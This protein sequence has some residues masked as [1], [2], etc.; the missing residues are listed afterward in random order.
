[1]LCSKQ[2]LYSALEAIQNLP[3]LVIGDIILDR[4]IWG[5]VDRISSEAPVPV[6]EVKRTEDRL[7]G[8]GNVVRNLR[9]V[10]AKVKLCGLIGEDDE[11]KL[12]LELLKAEGVEH[13][14]VI[15]DRARPTT[16]KTRVIAHAQQVVRIDRESRT[17]AAAPLQEGF[18]AVVDAQLDSA[19]V[20]ILSDYGKAAFSSVL[21]RKL[22]QALDQKRLGSGIRPLIVDPHPANYDSYTYMTVGKPNRREAEHG[23]GMKITDRES[24]EKAARLLMKRW[25]ADGMLVSLGEDGLVLV[26]NSNK[27]SIILETVAQEVFDV[28]GAGDTITALFS[29]ATG[30]GVSPTVAGVLANIAA[31]IVVS[32]IGT[33]AVT[34]E[35]LLAKIAE[36]S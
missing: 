35:G 29:A 30:A 21:M 16:I 34:K 23:S 18:A 36:I 24:A 13:E 22:K 25:H 19:K 11:G 4:Y 12:I 3:I 10:G 17:A 14:G 33:V 26:S 20:V 1:M 2:E 32:E 9:G 15:I 27:E 6:V 5:V 28:S 7:G 8:A 31:G